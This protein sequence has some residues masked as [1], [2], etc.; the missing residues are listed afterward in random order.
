M[1][2]FRHLLVAVLI[3][4]FFS[5]CSS[6]KEW[7]SAHYDSIIQG[8]ELPKL[9]LARNQALKELTIEEEAFE[10]LENT[11]SL[12][13]GSDARFKAV[14]I[15]SEKFYNEMGPVVNAYY[16]YN[17]KLLE[18]ITNQKT[19]S[20]KRN[21]LSKELEIVRK[22]LK[23]LLLTVIEVNDSVSREKTKA[24]KAGF[25]WALKLPEMKSAPENIFVARDIIDLPGFN[26]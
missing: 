11:G 3:L 25:P 9:R 14:I 23:E 6:T 4:S 10:R 24:Y 15:R 2:Y 17:N 18:K 19:D 5:A 13:D 26:G 12:I 7:A 21:E 8:S 16:T 20:H 1:A 22:D